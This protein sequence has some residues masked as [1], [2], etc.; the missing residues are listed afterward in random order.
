MKIK[1]ELVHSN[2]ELINDFDS[3]INNIENVNFDKISEHGFSGIEVVHYFIKFVMS[4]EF[5]QLLSEIIINFIK[6]DDIKSFKINN[7]E[8]K[9]YNFNEVKQLL[10]LA[11]E[12]QQNNK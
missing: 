2:Y 4:K 6:K 9:G 8:I 1:L 12:L 5:F 10:E 11:I 7:I 3:E